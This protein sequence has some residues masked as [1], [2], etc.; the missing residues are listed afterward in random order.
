[1]E[2]RYDGVWTERVKRQ[3]EGLTEGMQDEGRERGD[4]KELE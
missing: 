2:R 4:E 3:M 1:M